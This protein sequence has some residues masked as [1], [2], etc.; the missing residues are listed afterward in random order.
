MD[1]RIAAILAVLLVGA[2]PASARITKAWECSGDNRSQL[3][4][5]ELHKHATKLSELRI[6][7]TLGRSGY[8]FK[9]P[10]I[11]PV[12]NV[13]GAKLNGKP[14]RILPYNPK[15]DEND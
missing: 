2:T 15:W 5:V 9:F 14:C 4:T 1:R 3:I 6:T 11:P 7:G 13:E 8:N 12:G 10:P